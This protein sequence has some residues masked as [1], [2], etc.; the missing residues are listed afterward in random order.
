MNEIFTKAAE[1]FDTF[2]PKDWTTLLVSTFALV[3]SILSLRQ[4][5]GEGR[6]VLRKQLTD[7]L[8]KLSELN[9]EVAKFRFIREK[10]DEYPPNY[11][12]L[13]NDQR[14]FIVRQAAFVASRIRN[15]VSPYEYLVLAGGFDSID[16]TYQAERLYK[17]ASRTN[18]QIDRGIAIRGYAR[19]LFNRGRIEESR[20]QYSKAVECFKGDSDHLRHH[21]GDTYERWA[22]QEREWKNEPEANSLLEHSIAEY[23]SLTNPARQSYEVTR[24]M[25]LLPKPRVVENEVEDK[26]A[27]NSFNP[28]A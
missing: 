3:F 11:I 18:D 28:T 1:F 16:D 15:L 27:Y 20:Q 5:A 10:K 14:R 7:L 23:R 9:I 2:Q 17:L 19:Y 6:L 22:G 12:G 26:G 8:E 25:A 4:K 21:R 24:T 13:L